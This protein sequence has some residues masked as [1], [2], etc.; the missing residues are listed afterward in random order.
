MKPEYINNGKKLNI[1]TKRGNDMQKS[2]KDTI[3]RFLSALILGKWIPCK[4]VISITGL[5][6][7]T[8]SRAA[9]RLTIDSVIVK[10]VLQ[11][12]R[13]KNTYYKLV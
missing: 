3:K 5:T 6:Q 11:E 9:T 4:D 1:K 13:C 8:I 12:G 7:G 2:S 10:K